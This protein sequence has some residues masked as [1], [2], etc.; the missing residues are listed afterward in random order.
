MD[1]DIRAMSVD[2]NRF[3]KAPAQTA[4][5]SSASIDAEWLVYLGLALLALFLRVTMLDTTPITDEEAQ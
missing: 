2:A 3:N 5:E 4:P 1:V